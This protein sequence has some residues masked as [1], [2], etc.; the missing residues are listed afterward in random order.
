MSDLGVPK[1]QHGE[2]K[3]LANIKKLL[4]REMIKRYD[5]AA[6]FMNTKVHYMPVVESEEDL[7][8]QGYPD[9]KALSLQSLM[10]SHQ[11]LQKLQFKYLAIVM[12]LMDV[13]RAESESAVRL[14]DGFS[15]MEKATDPV[16]L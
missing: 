10:F 15:K 7:K 11:E 12:S 3:N 16:P 9:A 14:S 5:I 1:L 2:I 6:N 8:N 13:L 4:L